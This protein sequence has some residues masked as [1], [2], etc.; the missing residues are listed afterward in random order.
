MFEN[1]RKILP[2]IFRTIRQVIKTDWR[3]SPERKI[4]FLKWKVIE[5]EISGMTKEYALQTDWH[6]LDEGKRSFIS[7]IDGC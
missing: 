1:D 4:N 2:F 5:H 6:A 3:T 7:V